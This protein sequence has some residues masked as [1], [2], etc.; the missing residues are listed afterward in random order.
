MSNPFR[1]LLVDDH[2]VLRA[3]LRLL[4][5]AEVNF[6]VVG[7]AQDGHQAMHLAEKLNPDIVILD[8][9]MPRM[10]GLD[11]LRSLHQLNP[12]CRV[13]VLTMHK[14]EGYL[15]RALAAGAKGYVLKQADDQ[16]L[17]VALRAV[18]R[19]DIYVPPAL[20]PS[21]LGNLIPQS[22][23][24]TSFKKTALS[25]REEQVLRLVAH[26]YTSQEV[27]E[28]LNLAVTTVETYRSRAMKK[29][30]LRG[31]VQLVQYAI[32]VGWLSQE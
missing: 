2:A 32:H 27:S 10:G 31:R 12:D 13:L 11:T 23:E 18:A 17:L 28:Q 9:T 21:L 20:A 7:E 19:D 6:E 26:G 22:M 15:R 3:G 1:V 8:L 25:E 30:E 14:D 4:L 16:E 29:L 5:D 24:E